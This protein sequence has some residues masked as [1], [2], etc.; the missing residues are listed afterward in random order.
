MS[1]KLSGLVS[2]L[3][4]DSMV[5][6][7]VSAYSTKKDNLVK[8]QT[9]L[10]WTQDAWKDMNSKI[11]SFYTDSLSNMRFS[12]TFSAMK[13]TTASDDSKVTISGSATAVNGTQTLEINQLAQAGYLTGA[14][15]S[16]GVSGVTKLSDL[17][18]SIG[19]LNLTVSGTSKTID[20]TSDM[21]VSGFTSALKDAGL[22]ANFDTTQQ[23]FF[24]S[25]A[26]TGVANDFSFTPGTPGEVDTLTKLG[27]A[28]AENAGVAP[29]T[30]SGVYG[31]QSAG[32]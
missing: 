18:V 27:L 20:I 4:T 3:D 9:K 19:T 11:Y 23:R 24:I 8:A 30:N 26:S 31:D 28:T 2:G 12:S 15:L 6:E 7:L 21:T 5:K 1:I 14:Q 25:S 10:S 29:G 32:P 17:G 16:G 22:N 13:K